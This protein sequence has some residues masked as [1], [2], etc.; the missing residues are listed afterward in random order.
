MNTGINELN[1][2]FSIHDNYLIVTHEKPDGDAFGAILGMYRLFIENGKNVDALLPEP[3]PDN[4]RGFIHK[5]VINKLPDTLD[6]YSWIVVLDCATEKRVALGDEGDSL[7]SLSLPV[8]NIDHHPDNLLYGKKNL[9]LPDAAATAEIICRMFIN[10]T[11]WQFSRETATLLLL[12]IIMDTGGFRFSNTSAQVME[13][14]AQLLCKGAD[15]SEIIRYMFFSRSLDYLKFESDLILNHIQLA[16]EGRYAWIYLADEILERHHVDVK[17]TE[18]LIDNIRSINSVEIAAILYQRNNGFKC[19]LRSKN[20]KYP[21]GDIARILNGGGHE[22]A[23]GAFIET[24]NIK[25]AEKILLKYVTQVLEE[26]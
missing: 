6:G 13:T 23:A 4:Y 5:G 18:G 25:T 17:D 22:L 20:V 7:V 21:V 14:S 10:D 19:S 11:G 16:C 26:Q 15:H 12:G 1:K 2:F 24:D 3:I 8:I 9:V